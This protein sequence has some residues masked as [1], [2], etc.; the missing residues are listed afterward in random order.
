MQLWHAEMRI[1]VC[2]PAYNDLPSLPALQSRDFVS[3]AIRQPRS[4]CCL[5][6]LSHLF[7]STRAGYRATEPGFVEHVLHRQFGHTTATLCCKLAKSLGKRDIIGKPFA[8]QQRPVAR[9]DLCV[10]GELAGEAAA[11]IGHTGQQA[12]TVL[13]G[14]L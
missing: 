11:L 8:L 7:H 4:Q 10:G 14:G 3:L 13:G 6:V 1:P 5:N 2:V 12:D 9:G